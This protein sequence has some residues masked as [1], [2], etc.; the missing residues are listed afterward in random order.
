MIPMPLSGFGKAFNLSQEKEIMPY[1]LYTQTFVE[2]GG[3]ANR[4]Q[5]DYVTCDWSESDKSQLYENLEKWDCETQEGHFDMIKYSEHYCEID[6]QV[7]QTGYMIFRGALL[8]KYGLDCLT[9]PTMASLSDA[10]F[11]RMGCFIGVCELAGVILQFLA[12]SSVGGRVMCAENKKVKT[13]KALADFDGVSLYPSA[14]HRIP[15]YLIGSPKIWDTSVDLSACDGYFLKIKVTKVGKRYKFPICRLKTDEGGNNWTNDLEGETITVDRFTLE[16]LIK[17][18]QVEYDILQGY[19]FNEGRNDKINQVILTMFNDRLRYKAEGN[20]LQLVIKLMMNA[21]Y[22]ITGLKPI[23]V[24]VKYVK[25][26]ET[27]NFIENHFNQIREFVKLSSDQYRFE[28][29][30]EIDTHFNRQ[31]V[32]CEILS[33]SK[34]IMN[35]VM[36]TAEDMGSEIYYTDTDS[37]HIESDKVEPLADA[38]REKYGRELIGEKLGQFHCDFEF[39][40][41]YHTVDGKLVKVGKSV[42]VVGD[43]V[44]VESVFLGKKSYIDRIRDDAGNEAFHIRLKGIPG[45]CVQAKVDQCYGGDP[46]AM[47]NDL[48]DGATVEFDLTSGGNCVF[49]T[50]KDHT[51]TTEKL[52]RKVRFQ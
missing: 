49:K 18:Q 21:A 50:R 28:T 23:E 52:A 22:G 35:E 29:Y 46:M 6:V 19:Y 47:F 44:A 7:L 3:F 39:D 26:T 8:D 25:D 36:C 17:H 9:Y 51:I 20:P 13:T 27:N 32:A 33:V 30:K 37:M 4:N 48:F 42:E 5:L 15:G 34:A 2:R 12:N 14:M 24:D 16:D 45:K 11:N 10:Y 31:H 38:F 43:P 41:S 40:K 1:K